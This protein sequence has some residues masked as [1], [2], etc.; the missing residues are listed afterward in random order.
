MR[1]PACAG[2]KTFAAKEEYG[3]V[4]VL[5]AAAGGA[6][7]AQA[8]LTHRFRVL[9]KD[10]VATFIK[11][12][13]LEPVDGVPLIYQPGDYLQLDIT[14]YAERHL[15]DIAVDARL[16]TPGVRSR[17]LRCGRQ[18]PMP[19]AVIIRWR[20]IP[21]VSRGCISTHGWRSHRLVAI[22]LLAQIPPG[23]LP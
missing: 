9:A 3:Q 22:I 19:V 4:W 13:V 20:A 2:L 12:L 21:R 18:T 7:L 5:I 23:Y 6:G 16:P 8:S 10:N 17:G 15:T 11:E 1:Q 14:A